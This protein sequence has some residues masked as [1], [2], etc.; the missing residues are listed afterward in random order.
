MLNGPRSEFPSR[1]M[2]AKDF[3]PVRVSLRMMF[4]PDVSSPS[5]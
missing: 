2:P 3:Y 1:G 4:S 5:G